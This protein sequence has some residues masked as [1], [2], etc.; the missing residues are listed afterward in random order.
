MTTDV[1]LALLGFSFVT[2]ISPGPNNLMLLASGANF[3]LRRSVPHMLGIVIGFPVMV[4]LVGLGA[5]RVFEAW[6]PAYTILKVVSVAYMLWLA[7]KIAHAAAPGEG[8]SRANPLSFVQSA[9]FQWVNPKAWSMAL[10][11]VTLYAT[12]SDARSVV[13]VAACYVGVSIL[14]TNVWVI[15]GVQVRRFLTDPLRLRVFNWSMAAL[16][17]ASLVPALIAG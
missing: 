13:L 6:P 12:G 2:V 4:I 1:F 8:P 10:G 11:A 17:I 16:L 5:S 3:G 14:S 9:G 15:L 7:W